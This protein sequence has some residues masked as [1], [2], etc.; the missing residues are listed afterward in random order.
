MSALRALTARQLQNLALSLGIAAIGDSDA[1]VA[2]GIEADLGHAP[3]GA[4]RW[5]VSP[6]NAN[7]LYQAIVEWLIAVL[8]RQAFTA[9][10]GSSLVDESEKQIMQNLPS[11]VVKADAAEDQFW[12]IP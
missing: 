11:V 7:D 12:S 2:R 4:S 10:Y 8:D 9:G 5:I 1:S 3:L 6:T